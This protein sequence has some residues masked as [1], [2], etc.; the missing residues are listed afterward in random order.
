MEFGSKPICTRSMENIKR[1]YFSD[2]T[3]EFFYPNGEF[4]GMLNTWEFNDLRIQCRQ[5]KMPG[6]YAIFNGEKC[7]INENGR[8]DRWPDGFYDLYEKQLDKLIF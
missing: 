8:V 7:T 2:I 4:F 3:V 6:F 1:N 5:N